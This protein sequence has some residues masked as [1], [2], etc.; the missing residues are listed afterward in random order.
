MTDAPEQERQAKAQQKVGEQGADDRGA[1]HF[2]EASAQSDD[3]D[4]QFRE[5][6]EGRV[7]EA[8]D[9]GAGMQGDLLRPLDDESCERHDGDR[10]TEEHETGR[11]IADVVDKGGNG[12]EDEQPQE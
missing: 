2:Q 5:V 4:D 10:G 11:N 3:G 1:H 8:S 6:A 9:R 7:E 12:R